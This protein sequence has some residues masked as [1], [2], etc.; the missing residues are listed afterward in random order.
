MTN[1]QLSATEVVGVV[2]VVVVGAVVDTDDD[3]A[4]EV[5]LDVVDGVPATDGAPIVVVVVVPGIVVP[6]AI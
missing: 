3:G 1:T 5:V 6:A 2:V 4:V